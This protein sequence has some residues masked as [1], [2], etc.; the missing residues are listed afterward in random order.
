MQPESPQTDLIT[1]EVTGFILDRRARRLSLNTIDYY[2]RELSYFAGFLKQRE[3][4]SMDALSAELIRAYLLD[5]STHRNPG[6]VHASWRALKAFHRWYEDEQDDDSQ[7]RNPMR[8]VAAPKINTD[9]RPG[10]NLPDFHRLVDSCDSTLLGLRDHAIFLLL[11]DTGVRRAELCALSLSDINTATGAVT[12]EHG[13]GNRRRTVYIGA[14]TRRAL[15]RYLRKRS[16]ARPTDPLFTTKLGGR[17]S[18]KGLEQMLKNRSAR[19][20]LDPIPGLHDFRR[21]FAVSCLKN[22]MDVFTLQRLMGHSSLTIL[23]RYLHQT[24]GDLEGAFSQHG[25]VDHL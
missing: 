19:A 7:W 18:S 16:S 14:K 12:V 6:G 8:K 10:I 9:P 20:G 24:E 15:A 21:A 4:L 1:T 25:P 23:R 2:S 5:L 22:G 13:K 17:M 11:L 3:V